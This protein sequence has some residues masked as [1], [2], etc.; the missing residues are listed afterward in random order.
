MV[1]YSESI[2]LPFTDWKKLGIGTL[3]SVVPIVNFI[4]TGY[5]LQCA[6]L[7]MKK[8][9]KKLPEWENWGEMFVK[10]FAASMIALLYMLPGLLII[11][12]SI[13]SALVSI[14]VNTLFTKEAI[15]LSLMTA[16]TNNLGLFLLGGMIA[17][18]GL[19]FTP[20]ATM[21]YAAKG[22]FGAG[23][24]FGKV[25]NKTMTSKYFVAVLFAIGYGLLVLIPLGLLAAIL[26]VTIVVPPIID[27]FASI[28]LGVTLMTVYGQVYAETK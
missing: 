7:G 12:L 19:F 4:A 6:R 15:E 21:N 23:F 5:Q 1:K 16:I 18:I 11:L 26:E 14:F 25:W 20:M 3:V 9:T 10:G 28:V 13:F 17:L 8:R 2:R 22:K 27:A 24:D